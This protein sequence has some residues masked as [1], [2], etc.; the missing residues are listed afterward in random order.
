M[1]KKAFSVYVCKHMSHGAYA[2][3]M[4]SLLELVL[5]FHNENMEIKFMLS[6]FLEGAFDHWAILPALL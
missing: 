5:S 2:E 3:V 4:E 1:I 6:G